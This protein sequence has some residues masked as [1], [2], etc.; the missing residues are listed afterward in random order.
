MFI[1]L[2]LRFTI[3]FHT[4]F[5][6]SLLAF[7]TSLHQLILSASIYF[8]LFY[9]A[10]HVAP[11]YLVTFLRCYILLCFTLFHYALLCFMLCFPHPASLQSPSLLCSCT[12]S[13]ST[14]SL[15]ICFISP[16]FAL[17]SLHYIPVCFALLH[18][19]TLPRFSL[20][21][22]V[23]LSRF[24]LIFLSSVSQVLTSSLLGTSRVLLFLAQLASLSLAPFYFPLFRFAPSRVNP[25]LWRNPSRIDGA[26]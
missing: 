2:F 12:G 11:L 1:I 22:F 10:L 17:F 20:L 7:R 9:N 19:F 5:N 24:A 25:G 8:D 3:T 13:L 4:C 15:S 16:Y 14:F 6:N 23:I 18:F 21:R 26:M